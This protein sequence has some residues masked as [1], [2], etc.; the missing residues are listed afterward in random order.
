[1]GHG[2]VFARFRP[3]NLTPASG[4]GRLGRFFL[5]SPVKNNFLLNKC[6]Q[7]LMGGLGKWVLIRRAKTW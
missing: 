1:M 5:D 7:V 2:V 6:Y 3:V 4:G